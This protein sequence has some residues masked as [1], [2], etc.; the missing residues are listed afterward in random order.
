MIDGTVNISTSSHMILI[1]W[2]CLPYPKVSLIPLV[3]NEWLPN[4]STR[5]VV[6]PYH[7][8]P[9]TMKAAKN[10]AAKLPDRTVSIFP[11]PNPIGMLYNI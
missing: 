8:V 5:V 4:T 6:E 9:A 7:M 1:A 11:M 2:I 3:T 10:T